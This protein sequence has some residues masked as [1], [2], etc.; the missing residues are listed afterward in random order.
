VNEKESAKGLAKKADRSCT[1]W[2]NVVKE[3]RKK[4]RE[5]SERPREESRE[6]THASQDERNATIQT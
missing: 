3:G 5:G 4:V 6:L 1:S 2:G